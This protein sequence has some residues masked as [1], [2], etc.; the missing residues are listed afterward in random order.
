MSFELEVIALVSGAFLL[1]MFGV[2]WATEKGIIP[3][4]LVHHPAVYVLSLGIYASSWTFYGS[5]GISFDDGYAFLALYFGVS[6]AFLLAPVLLTPLLR[7]TSSYQLSSLPDLFAFR[8]RSQTAGTL[9]TLLLLAISLPLMALQIQAIADST[10]LISAKPTK[11]FFVVGYCVAIIFF[12]L[13]FGTRHLSSRKHHHG[14]VFTMAFGALIKLSVMLLLGAVVFFQV[15]D[16]AEGLNQWIEQNPVITERMGS[17]LEDGPWRTLL[18]MFFASAVAMPHM[19]HMIFAENRDAKFLYTASWGLPLYLLLL[20]LSTPLILWAGIELQSNFQPEYYSLAIGLELQQPWLTLIVYIGG[21]CAAT[22]IMVVS[23]LALSSMLMNHIVLPL[24][25]PTTIIPARI[26]IY[27]WL[28]NIKRCLVVF[29]IASSYFF[30]VILENGTDIHHFGIVAYSGA[31]Q[32]LPG[33]LSTLYWKKANRQGFIWGL[34]AGAT[35]WLCILLLPMTMGVTIFLFDF[36]SLIS[37]S[38]NDWHLAAALCLIVNAIVFYLVSNFTTSSNAEKSAADVCLVKPVRPRP[39]QIPK[40]NSAFEFQEMLSKPLGAEIAKNEV[41]KALGDL[42]LQPD[43]RRPHA[44]R[45]LRDRIETNLSSIM[46]PSVAHDLIKSS[47]PLDNNKGYVSQDIHFIETQL[48]AYHSKLTGLAAEL[49]GLRRYHR[50]TLKSL[51]MPVCSI[52]NTESGNHQVIL[53]NQAMSSMTGIPSEEVLGHPLQEIPA[54]WNDLIENFLNSNENHLNKYKVEFKG[55][56]RFFNLHKAH[57]SSGRKNQVMLLEDQTEAQMLENQ[58]FHN[59]RLAS[60]GQLAAGVA[61]E[62]GNPITGIDCLAQELKFITDDPEIEIS[63]K[64]ILEQTK[65]VNRIVQTLVT[66]AHSGQQSM[67][68]EGKSISEPVNIH[69]CVHE[70]ISLLKLNQ[71]ND[72]IVFR[73]ECDPDIRVSGNSQKLQQIFI[74]LLSNASDASEDHGS[75]TISAA[76]DEMT[77]TISVEDQGHGIPEPIQERLFEPFFTTKEAGKGTG[78][79]LALT[80]NIIKEHFGSIQVISPVD[81]IKQRGTRFIIAL[82]CFE[83]DTSKEIPILQPQGE[84]V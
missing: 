81:T 27:R 74:N 65:R 45:R 21:I 63:S 80:W 15:F 41:S 13:F 53:W 1:T 61:H 35:V 5:L 6:G 78:L 18:L 44:L 77:V 3:L 55:V 22:G 25:Q 52:D 4:K 43:E 34:I 72:S 24:Y 84:A 37:L 56:A 20:S 42:D 66:Y 9:S 46:G 76:G 48:E 2:A 28:T 38:S 49:D 75:I 26:N 70:A 11:N 36:Q 40:A 30:Y 31:M 39:Q 82:P 73:N 12:T 16:G 69:Q 54:P 10:Y 14:L 33:T 59:E 58:L 57:V 23:T 71:K 79:G 64:Q 62:I 17:K 68:D 7:I 32:L 67:N 51:P 29:L 83:P 19:F 50:E 60:I 47:L 8:F